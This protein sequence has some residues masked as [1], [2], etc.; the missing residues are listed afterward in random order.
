MDP[1]IDTFIKTQIPSLADAKLI[2][3]SSQVV[4]G[5]M[6]RY[7]Y[8]KDSTE[9]TVAV[10]EQK[11]VKFIEVNSIEKVE[12]KVNEKGQT[13]KVKTTVRTDERN[14]QKII[15]ELM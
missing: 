12:Q 4:A 13:V 11:W 14:I 5:T 2:K 3:T 1:A 6:Y 15:S 10:W 7:T 8:S 9:W